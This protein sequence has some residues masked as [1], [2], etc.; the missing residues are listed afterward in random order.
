MNWKKIVY[1]FIWTS[2]NLKLKTL[3][4]VWIKET[5]LLMFKMIFKVFVQITMC[6][7]VTFFIFFIRSL[8]TN[9]DGSFTI[10][11]L[12]LV[13]VVYLWAMYHMFCLTIQRGLFQDEGRREKKQERRRQKEET[14]VSTATEGWGGGGAQCNSYFGIN[15]AWVEVV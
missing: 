9:F 3:H 2:I 1:N 14:G 7:F 6:L 8:L 5:L 12:C 10:Y 13:T 11:F 15:S 4:H